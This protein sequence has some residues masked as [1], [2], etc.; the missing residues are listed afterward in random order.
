MPNASDI[1]EIETD[2]EL[3]ESVYMHKKGWI[4]QTTGLIF[5]LMIVVAAAL[6]F[7]GDG[8]VSRVISNSGNMTVDTQRFY[9]RDAILELKV[10]IRSHN[11]SGPKLSFPNHYVDKFEIQSIVPEP[12]RSTVAGENVIYHFNGSGV[13]TI[14]FY[15]IPQSLGE[16]KGSVAMKGEVINLNHY[17]F[18]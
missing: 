7:F 2:L 16:V 6:G 12:E 15:L 3:D 14:T 9:R 1:E 10:S 8:M 18:P 11:D 4:A 5:M 13:Q 17:I